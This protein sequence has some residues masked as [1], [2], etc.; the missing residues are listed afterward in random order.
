MALRVPLVGR[1]DCIGLWRHIFSEDPQKVL[2]ENETYFRLVKAAGQ[3]GVGQVRQM[4]NLVQVGDVDVC[5]SELETRW[6]D[7]VAQLAEEVGSETYVLNAG[8]FDYVN[9]VINGPLNGRLVGVNELR[10]E[11]DSDDA[12]GLGDCPYLIVRQIAV[13][14]AQGSR[15]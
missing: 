11:V 10:K 14:V 8:N 3:Q 4:M 13:V 1:R 15:R 12:T 7:V 2:T 9:E 6:E 5:I